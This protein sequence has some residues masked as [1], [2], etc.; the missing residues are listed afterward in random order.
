ML[1]ADP[2]HYECLTNLAKIAYARSDYL[3]AKELF[4]RAI[5]VKPHFD[6]TVYHLALVLYDMRDYERSQ[7][8]FNEVVQVILL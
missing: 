3:K 6:K 8:L 7:N 1:D 5:V 2:V 4:E